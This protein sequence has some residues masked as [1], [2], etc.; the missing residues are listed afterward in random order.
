MKTYTVETWDE[1]KDAFKLIEQDR[2]ALADKLKLHPGSSAILYR[3]HGDSDW[4][5][6]TTLERTC[7]ESVLLTEY[8]RHILKTRPQVEAFSNTRWELMGFDEYREWAQ[9]R[10]D[11]NWPD[12]PGYE[13][14][15]YLRHHGFPS[16]LLDWSQSPYVAAFFAYSNIPH[17]SESVAIYGYAESIGSGKVWSSNDPL[18]TVRGPYARSH[19]RHFL[20]QCKYTVCSKIAG[21][22]LEYASHEEVFKL[23]KEEQ[24]VLWKIVA[25]RSSVS[26]ALKDLDFMN[27]NALS[28]MGSEDALIQTLGAREYIYNHA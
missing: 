17:E 25:P 10:S 19:K 6:K 13:Y 23:E 26:S 18:I 12:Y 27:V 14:M 22:G 4:D 8:Y 1:V 20:Q 24:D 16:P 2:M 21:N 5:L 3:G 11:L 7:D 28:L 15:I 9:S